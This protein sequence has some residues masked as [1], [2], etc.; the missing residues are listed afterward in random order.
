MIEIKYIYFE[1]KYIKGENETEPKIENENVL[2]IKPTT[3][4][5]GVWGFTSITERYRHPVPTYSIVK[6]NWIDLDKFENENHEVYSKLKLQVAE[7]LKMIN[8]KLI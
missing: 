6:Q 3:N 8:A 4:S 7:V 1:I 2:L 5:S